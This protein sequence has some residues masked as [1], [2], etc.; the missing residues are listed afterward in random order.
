MKVFMRRISLALIV[1]GAVS[2]AAI[3]PSVIESG[4]SWEER[5]REL[6]R[7]FPF[8]SVH[9]EGGYYSQSIDKDAAERAGISKKTFL[10]AS[11]MLDY[12]NRLAFEAYRS[13]ILGVPMVEVELREFPKVE[14]FFEEA[15]QKVEEEKETEERRVDGLAQLQIGPFRIGVVRVANAELNNHRRNRDNIV[16]ACG[17]FWHP[18]PNYEPPESWVP[19]Q[20]PRNALLGAGFHRTSPKYACRGRDCSR[21]YTHSRSYTT[22]DHGPCPRPFFRDHG[23]V[24]TSES[25]YS[26]QQGEPNPE[27]VFMNPIRWPHSFWLTYVPWWHDAF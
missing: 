12:Q 22:S 8:I 17:I 2:I 20:D 15:T 9:D 5:T 14:E 4:P 11:E 18:V 21:D 19:H 24:D 27:S 6:E 1:V 26:I 10:L 16:L 25:G 13:E 7:A 3:L 23:W